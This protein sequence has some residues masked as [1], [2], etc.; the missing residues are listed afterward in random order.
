MRDIEGWGWEERGGTWLS[1][2]TFGYYSSSTDCWKVVG[3]NSC[4]KF[5]IFEVLRANVKY[6]LLCEM[7]AIFESIKACIGNRIAIEFSNIF[8]CC[9]N[10]FFTPIFNYWLK[11]DYTLNRR[12]WIWNWLLNYFLF[13]DFL[14]IKIKTKDY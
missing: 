4:E 10:T 9:I 3:T 6:T 12:N 14:I 13:R 5:P 8:R 1:S 7:Y 11:I 2:A